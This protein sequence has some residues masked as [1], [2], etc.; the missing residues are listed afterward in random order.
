VGRKKE[1]A[2]ADERWLLTYA[3]MITLLM[4]LFMVLFSM[5]VINKGKFDELARSLRE[6]FN[7]PL[8]RG[9][10]AVLNVGS[11][12]PSA[13]A[14]SELSSVPNPVM[15]DANL[16]RALAQRALNA[17]AISDA[18]KLGAIED[19]SLQAAKQ[20]IDKKVAD[21]KLQ[22]KVQTQITSKGLV[23]RLITDKV[24]FDIGSSTIRP[25]A[26]PLLQTVAEAVNTVQH[27][28]IRVNGHTDAIPFA[29]DPFGNE[30]L[31]VDRALA[32]F[33]FMQEH[34]FSVARHADSAS[35]G[36]GARDPIVKN[37]PVTGA[38]PKNRRVEVIVQRLNYVAE[39]Q[40]QANGPIG[41]SPAGGVGVVPSAVKITP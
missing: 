27:N 33:I 35:G 16:K 11:D 38:G 1:H 4:A 40:A 13:S 3:D 20:A 5:A 25:E 18:Q 6:S 17:Q 10:T 39:A 32:V 24:L 41:A 26:Y 8:D 36:F 7:G 23:I 28:P 12:N 31:S 34:G 30:R 14:Q 37:D 15:A 22:D 19:K 29:G 21:L 9:G 2:H